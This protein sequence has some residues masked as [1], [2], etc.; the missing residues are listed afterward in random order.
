MSMKW[1]KGGIWYEEG[2]GVE[3]CALQVGSLAAWI[4]RAL[5]R[6]FSTE[7]IPSLA[8]CT[9]ASPE[10]RTRSSASL[11]CRVQAAS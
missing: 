10:A 9:E 1:R 11:N 6:C 7:I 8:T 4:S 3:S 5:E 2:G